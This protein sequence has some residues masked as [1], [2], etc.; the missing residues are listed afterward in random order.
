L[1]RDRR[2][3]AE[4]QAG[5]WRD[6]GRG[7]AEQTQRIVERQRRTVEGLWRDGGRTVEG[8]RIVERQRM[9]SRRAAVC[10]MVGDEWWVMNDE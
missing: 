6:R 3:T 2:R 8:Q 9:Q 4:G 5:L 7:A 10:C 1:R